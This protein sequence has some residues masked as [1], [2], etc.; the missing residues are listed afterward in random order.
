VNDIK[1]KEDYDIILKN[2][3]GQ[4]YLYIPELAGPSLMVFANL[5]P[6]HSI[7]AKIIRIN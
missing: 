7:N 1:S 5:Q 3:Y 6:E 4:F 2:R